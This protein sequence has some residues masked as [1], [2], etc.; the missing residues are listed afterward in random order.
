MSFEK[1]TLTPSKDK[2]YTWENFNLKESLDVLTTRVQKL[3][4]AGTAEG[5]WK[6]K[7]IIPGN[8]WNVNTFEMMALYQHAMNQLDGGQLIGVDGKFWPSTHKNLMD[9]QAI[10]KVVPSDGLPGPQTTEALIQALQVAAKPAVAASAQAPAAA[11]ER[12]WTITLTP[13]QSATR[14]ALKT[15][16]LAGIKLEDWWCWSIGSI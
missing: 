6:Y 16:L 12:V 15:W 4:S 7:S 3:D 5:L 1:A 10:L 11:T 14:S 9:I 13:D 8:S 2:K